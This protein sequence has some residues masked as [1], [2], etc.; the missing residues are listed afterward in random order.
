MVADFSSGGHDPK[1]GP[2]RI[3]CD[4][5]APSGACPTRKKETHM[6]KDIASAHD[7]VRQGTRGLRQGRSAERRQDL[8]DCIEASD[9]A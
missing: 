6:P 3:A 4:G 5:S 7:M 8:A 2:A 9:R 1:T